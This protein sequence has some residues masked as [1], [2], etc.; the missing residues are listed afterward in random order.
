MKR[1]RCFVPF[2]AVLL[3]LIAGCSKNPSAPNYQKE[4]TV[5]GYLWGNEHLTADH[6][7]WIAYTEPVTDF[8]DANAAA[9]SHG[10]VT[11]R[12]QDTGIIHRLRERPERPGY[13]YND[14]VLVRPKTSY[15]LTVMADGK[16][17]TAVTTVPPVLDMITALRTDSVNVVRPENLSRQMPVFLQCENPDQV[18]LVDMNCTEPYQNAEY[19]RPFMESQK[20]PQNREEYDGGANGEPKHITAFARYKD[21]TSA[22]YPGQVV[23]FWYSSMLAFYGSYTMQVMAIDGNFHNYLYKEHP[24]FEGGIQGGIGVFGSMCGKVFRLRVVK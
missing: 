17:V 10:D 14:T 13:F 4:L 24:E 8:Y 1:I 2:A 19:I 5:F 18:V 23:I 21:F 12:E 7:I 20:F 9:L 6:A 16:T 11:L 3:V 15:Q 22:D